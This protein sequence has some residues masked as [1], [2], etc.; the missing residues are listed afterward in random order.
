MVTIIENDC[1][2]VSLVLGEPQLGPR[3]LYP[4]TSV[5]GSTASVKDMLNLISYADGEHSLLA[6]ADKCER[7]FAVF[8]PILAQ[9]KE[10]KLI[11]ID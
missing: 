2:P 1:I 4:M 7:P 3:G 6:I 10:H 9:L 8:L 11:R 5:K